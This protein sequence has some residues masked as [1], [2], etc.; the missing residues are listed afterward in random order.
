LANAL[1]RTQSIWPQPYP[2]RC[3]DR[4]HALGPEAM[5]RG[6]AGPPP[7]TRRGTVPRPL[8]KTRQLEAVGFL[9]LS[10]RYPW[11]PINLIEV[12]AETHQLGINPRDHTPASGSRQC[13]I[14]SGQSSPP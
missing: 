5:G 3:Q 4:R 10:N 13:G 11:L 2:L 1:R 9:S 14:P 8:R 6:V 12:L 7:R